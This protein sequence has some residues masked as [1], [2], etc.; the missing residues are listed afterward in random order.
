MNVLEEA[1]GGA[2]LWQRMVFKRVQAS[3]TLNPIVVTE[4]GI[5]T[6]VKLLQEAKA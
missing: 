6:E 2:S 3:K 5:L 1:V 4:L